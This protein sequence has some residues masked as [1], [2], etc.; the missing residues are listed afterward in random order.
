MRLVV[1]A[2]V[3]RGGSA[4]GVRLKGREPRSAALGGKGDPTKIKGKDGKK[5]QREQEGDVCLEEQ[6]VRTAHLL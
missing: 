5:W 1:T 2:T 3:S 6:L 4:P